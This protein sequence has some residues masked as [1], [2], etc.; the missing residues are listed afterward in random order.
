MFNGT[1]L[2][3][4]LT[5]K[6]LPMNGPIA[7]KKVLGASYAADFGLFHFSLRL[8]KQRNGDGARHGMPTLAYAEFAFSEVDMPESVLSKRV[9]RN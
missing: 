4:G 8:A 7:L 3:D 1:P 2:K 6:L 9:Q 5:A